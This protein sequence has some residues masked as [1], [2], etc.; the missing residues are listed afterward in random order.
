[1]IATKERARVDIR[2]IANRAAAIGRG[3]FPEPVKDI[4][5][6]YVESRIADDDV[7]VLTDDYAPT[8]N[9]LHP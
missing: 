7:P 4:A 1:M 6:S 5:I 3:L 9:L 2:A 8:D